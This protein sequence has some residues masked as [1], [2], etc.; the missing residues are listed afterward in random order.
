MGESGGAYP[1]GGTYFKFWLTG[2]AL[3]R[4]GRLLV[5]KRGISRIYGIFNHDEETSRVFS[6][7]YNVFF[8]IIVAAFHNHVTI[9]KTTLRLHSPL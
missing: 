9:Y 7:S 6:T 3:I 2:G 4:R 5:G 1:R 8:S